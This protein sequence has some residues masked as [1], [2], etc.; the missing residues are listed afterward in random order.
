M[1]TILYLV[2]HGETEGQ[3][4]Q[5]YHGSTDVGLSA[6]GSAQIKIAAA[7]IAGRL[8]A[9]SP[10]GWCN[11]TLA[12]VYCSGLLRAIG[13]AEILAGPQGLKPLEIADLGER[14][15]GRW[16]GLTFSEIERNDPEGFA[17]WLANPLTY[18]PEG[19]ENA[20]QVSERAIGAMEQIVARHEGSS[21]AVV[22]HGGVNRIILCHLLGIPL[23]NVFRIEQDYGAVSIIEFWD[24]Y[25]VVKL[26]NGRLLADLEQPG[27]KIGRD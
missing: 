20:L 6:R 19:G 15:F 5:C 10:D 4:R 13:S 1:V 3:D 22:A 21:I 11:R 16:E 7:F 17:A 25:P 27:A 18:R 14:S 24:A 2:R 26:M 9:A 23:E 8:R 12:A